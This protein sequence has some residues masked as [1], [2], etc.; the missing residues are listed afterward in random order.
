MEERGPSGGSRKSPE[1]KKASGAQKAT[2][3]VEDLG[4]QGPRGAG[5][6]DSQNLVRQ[7]ESA[8][9]G[10]EKTELETSGAGGDGAGEGPNFSQDPEG[11]QRITRKS[12]TI[13]VV[14][15]LLLLLGAVAAA[16]AISK[17]GRETPRAAEKAV[18]VEVAVAARGDISEV[19]SFTGRIVPNLEA[20]LVPKVPGQIEEFYVDV[21]DTV[22][23]GEALVKI[24]DDHIAAQVKQAEASLAA[25]RSSEEQ[26]RLEVERAAA[27]L[28]QAEKSF[29]IAKNNY[30]RGKFLLEQGAIS[31]AEF[32][33]NFQNPYISAESGWKQ[34]RA[35]FEAAR[36]RLEKTV[37]SQIDQA[38]AAFEAARLQLANTVVTAPFSGMVSARYANPGDMASTSQPLLTLVDLDQVKLKINVTEKEVNK[39]TVGQEV[40]VFVEAA[41]KRPFKGR[42]TAVAPA[43][44]PRSK[45]YPVE[46]LL[47]NKGHLLKPGMF[48]RVN[49]TTETR[50]NVL[51]I[52]VEAVLE[53]DGQKVVYVIR[54]GCARRRLIRTGL[55]GST[56]VEV[57]EGLR[58]GDRVVVTGQEFLIDGTAV[59]V[60]K[61][62]GGAK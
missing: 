56:C 23:K 3:S 41:G 34:A 40:E 61:S 13:F 17:K 6:P 46:I 2:D 55:T 5:E 52:P 43:A 8:A 4:S 60:V 54:N 38:E 51:K 12:R 22:S 48:A 50:K 59:T 62:E 53:E 57:L 35:A 27:A 28:S 19:V 31:Q 26:A 21:G 45:L 33:S 44:D 25:A 7:G 47:S 18:P 30:E 20:N 37:P 1:E 15:A 32:E 49:I 58:P 29:Q 14:L 36:A 9:E 39:I 24:D 11:P 16:Q 10:L 42:I